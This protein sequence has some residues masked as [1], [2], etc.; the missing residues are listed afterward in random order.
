MVPLL[1]EAERLQA[2]RKA[3]PDIYARLPLQFEEGLSNPCFRDGNDTLRCLPAFF[4]AGAMQCGN[5]D[6]WRR[7]QEHGLVAHK[8]DALSHWWTNHPRSRAGDFDKYLDRLS[9]RRTVAALTREPGTLIAEAS[10][11]TFTYVMAES[12]RLHYLYL[13]AF[14]S[15]HARCRSATPPAEVAAECRRK[16]YDMAHCYAAANAA[17]VPE[18]FNIPSLIATTM[19]ARPPKVI[20]LLRE[21]SVRLWVAFWTYGQYPARYGASAEGFSYYAGNQTA[22]YDRCVRT[23]ARGRRRCALR[24]E[25]YGSAEAGSTTT[26]TKSSRAPTRPSCPSGRRR[27]RAA[28]SC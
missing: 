8:H 26:A 5:S 7:L 10:P 28:T 21:P 14:A 24:F 27:C 25:G 9:G 17:A 19:A 18:A 16:S 12:L 6:L 4:L 15:C 20:A 23:D 1:S 2:I 3:A 13:D 11:A 22:A